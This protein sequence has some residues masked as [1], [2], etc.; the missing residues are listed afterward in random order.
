[1]G[2]LTNNHQLMKRLIC[3]AAALLLLASCGN[4]QKRS[5]NG[6][7]QRLRNDIAQMLLVGFRGTSLSDTC[8]IVRDIKQHHI[9]GVILFEYD[10]PSRSR[11]RNIASRS[12]LKQL[13]SQ[14]QSLDSETLLIGIDQEGGRVTRLKPQYGFPL[15]ASAAAS[16]RSGIDSVRSCARLTASTLRS[17]GINLNFAPCVDVNINPACPIIGKLERSFGSN[18]RRV[19]QCAAVWV[20]EQQRQGVVACLKHFPGHGSSRS[21]THLGLADVSDTWQPSELEPYKALID[22]AQA[23]PDDPSRQVRMIMTTHVFN[24]R[25]DSL[26]PATLSRP[27]LTGLLRDSLRFDGVII[28][29]D[30][31][32]GAMTQ[33]YSDTA[34]LRLTILA[35]ADLLCLSN[36]GANYDPDIVP[37]TIDLILSL[38]RSGDIP[39]ERIHQSAARIRRLK[40]QTKK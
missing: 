34:M 13:C 22:S 27:T 20:D 15:F 24:A 6:D 8:H 29:D 39:A 30:L 31:A 9:G 14:L 26:L 2:K 16:A 4:A 10:A 33:H 35:G 3:T 12:Q 36:N 40:Q 17:L 7:E 25:L 37:R 18:A 38:V 32:M 21:D 19:A 1:M 28:T 23:H 5:A 11:P